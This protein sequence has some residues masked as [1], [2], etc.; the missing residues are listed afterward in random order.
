MGIFDLERRDEAKNRLVRSGHRALEV[1]RNTLGPWEQR[2]WSA[3]GRSSA[4]E[5]S[6]GASMWCCV[7]TNHKERPSTAQRGDGRSGQSKR[8]RTDQAAKSAAAHLGNKFV[9]CGVIDVADTGRGRR[10]IEGEPAKLSR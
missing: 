9:G 2:R 3:R 10:G 4:L 1:K 6:L 7:S 8:N 5:T